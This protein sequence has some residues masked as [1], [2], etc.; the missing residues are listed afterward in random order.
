[1]GKPLF[2]LLAGVVGTSLLLASCS[3]DNNTTVKGKLVTSNDFEAVLGWGGSADPSISMEQ[4]HSGTSSVKV[5]PQNEY[6]LT[7][8]QALGKMSPAKIKNITVSAWIWLGSESAPS[9][10]VLSIDR[11]ALLNTPVYY[12]NIELAKEVKKARS[13]QL[14][15]KTFTLPDSIQATNQLK[16]YLWRAGSNENVHADDLT[17]SVEN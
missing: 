2:N 7:Y 8:T 12:G 14:V 6:S 16:C 15:T 10:I 13:W 4:A 5:G 11:S 3:G 1:M 17:L 9:S